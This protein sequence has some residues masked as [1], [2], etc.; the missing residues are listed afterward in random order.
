MFTL[1]YHFSR[2]TAM[3]FSLCEGR[4]SLQKTLELV[5]SPEGRALR[6]LG[7]IETRMGAHHLAVK[8]PRQCSNY[9]MLQPTWIVNGP[10]RLL[11]HL[12]SVICKIWC[13]FLS[14]A[15]TNS[16]DVCIFKFIGNAAV[17]VKF[18]EK[19]TVLKQYERT[20]RREKKYL[21][22]LDPEK[23][24]RCS[25]SK[26]A[27]SRAC[28]IITQQLLQMGK[29]SHSQI[30][31]PRLLLCEVPFTPGFLLGFSA[32]KIAY[33]SRDDLDQSDLASWQQLFC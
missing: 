26:L 31:F 33:H 27:R 22:R 20:N 29:I 28:L 24:T 21:E 3:R 7:W 25:E 19:W 11:N 17:N 9:W 14:A 23:E 4:H 6:S 2:H 15:Q 8:R 18:I 5:V 13:W 16:Y 12:S 32:T 30:A 1:F 10:R